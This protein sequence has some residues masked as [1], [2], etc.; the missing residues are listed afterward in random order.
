MKRSIASSFAAV[1]LAAALI[2]PIN[3][4]EPKAGTVD[5]KEKS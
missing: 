5:L 4:Q 1:G 2:V 3:L